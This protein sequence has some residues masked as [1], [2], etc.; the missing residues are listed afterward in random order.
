MESLSMLKK[1]LVIA[2]TLSLSLSACGGDTPNNTLG[3][4]DSSL[5][6]LDNSMSPIEPMAGPGLVSPVDDPYATPYDTG[7][8]PAYDETYDEAYDETY[9]D[10]YADAD[11]IDDPSLTEAPFAEPLADELPAASLP[12]LG[13]GDLSI[14]Q[15]PD[16]HVA[17]PFNPGG[18]SDGPISYSTADSYLIDQDRFNQWQAMNI[19]TD[20]SML[21]VAA[22]DLKSPSKGT[23]I[24]MSTSGEGWKDLGKSLIATITF[25][26]RGYAMD[27]TITGIALDKSGNLLVSDQQNRVY[28]ATAPKYSF[29]ALNIGG[30]IGTQ[31]AI[32][33]NGHYFISTTRGIQKLGSDFGIPS[34]F[35][36]IT[37]SGGL[38]AHGEQIYAVVGANSVHRLNANGQG[39][40][41]ISGLEN[42]IDVAVDSTGQ[43][44]V[45]SS[46]GIRWFDAAGVEQGEF[47]LGEFI[48]PKGLCLDSSGA[49]FVADAGNDYKD[50]KIIK[51][52]KSAGGGG[53]GGS[54]GGL[55]SLDPL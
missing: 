1:Y 45:L 47:G 3:S 54:L 8:A 38:A 19:T 55:D 37:P 27:P 17:E 48:A 12:E 25:G 52:T 4:L 18:S 32:F 22:A 13:G 20:G 21:Y 51:F 28:S 2:C 14:G 36:S 23:V 35:G 30:L 6:S 40:R 41:L 31:D 43:I 33:A 29:E 44:F 34:T 9:A 5:G 49:I 16:M 46:N 7:A 50:S 10:G 15:L 11:Y 26:A 42:A 39:T 24:Q 53:L